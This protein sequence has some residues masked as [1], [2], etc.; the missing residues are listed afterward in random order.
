MQAV[1]NLLRDIPGVAIV[2]RHLDRRSLLIQRRALRLAVGKFPTSP[3][4]SRLG[5]R[6]AVE[7]S[8]AMRAAIVSTLAVSHTTFPAISSALPIVRAQ[9]HAA[10]GGDHGALARDQRRDDLRF[11]IAK[12]GLALVGELRGN[13]LARRAA[14]PRRRYRTNPTPGATPTAG[15]TVVLPVPR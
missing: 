15:A 5:R 1:D 11:A 9:H 4:A 2:G 6:A 13:R 10:T 12:G 3:P 7:T 14:R 8:A